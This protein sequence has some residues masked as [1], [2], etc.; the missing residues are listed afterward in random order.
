MKKIIDLLLILFLLLFLSCGDSKNIESESEQVDIEQP[1]SESIDT[2]NTDGSDN[3]LLDFEFSDFQFQNGSDQYELLFSGYW[4]F[5]GY[6]SGNGF[7]RLGINGTDVDLYFNYGTEDPLKGVLDVDGKISFEDR[8]V[9]FDC[10]NCESFQLSTT[11]E[12]NYETKTVSIMYQITCGPS[13]GYIRYVYMALYDGWN[14]PSPY[15]QMASTENKIYDLIQSDL[16]CEEP[17]E[18]KILKLY[19]NDP[20]NSFNPVYSTFG[21]DEE[22]LSDLLSEYHYFRSLTGLDAGTSI[23]MCGL[24]IYIKCDQGLCAKTF[25]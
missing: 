22:E 4:A 14:Q 8:T 10:N 15:N 5:D 12:I 11:G 23:G 18:C 16:S 7:A 13:E 21:V 17:S 9:S 20:C 3:D 6:C 19:I 1:E 25:D 24:P 2:E